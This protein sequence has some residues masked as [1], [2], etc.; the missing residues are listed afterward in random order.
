[1][2]IIEKYVK[3][4][5][6]IDSKHI[7]IPWLLKSKSYLKILGLSYILKN[8]NLP[9]TFEPVEEVIKETHI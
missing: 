4:T 7:D 8:T 6:K 1:M 9:I 3:E 2:S 5:N